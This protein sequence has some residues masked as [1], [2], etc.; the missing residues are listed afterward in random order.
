MENPATIAGSAV[1]ERRLKNTSVAPRGVTSRDKLRTENNNGNTKR[2][3]RNA[4]RFEKGAKVITNSNL[5][6][7]KKRIKALA[8]TGWIMTWTWVLYV[9]QL[10]GF[11]FWVVG[12]GTG[13]YGEETVVG[14]ILDW[15]GL[16]SGTAEIFIGLGMAMGLISASLGFMVAF[17]LYTVRGVSCFKSIS[18]LILIPISLALVI[19]PFGIFPVV[20]IW[21]V[22]VVLSQE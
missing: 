2:F 8:V 9:I 16:T 19:G 21:C 4:R 17:G 14:Q 10:I 1:K 13:I 11:V 5:R 7:G 20:W 12:I 6:K 15:G 22:F 3:L 18:N